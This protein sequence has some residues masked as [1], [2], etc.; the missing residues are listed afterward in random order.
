MLKPP[1][2]RTPLHTR[3][4]TFRG[5][6]REDGLWDLEGELHDSKHYDYDSS[7]GFRRAGTPVHHLSLRVTLDDSFCIHDIE[8]SMDSTPFGECKVA[9]QTMKKMIGQRM[10]PGWRQA[11]DRTIGGVHGC[12]HL[13]ELLFNMATAAFQTLPAAFGGGDP[14]TPPRHLGQ[15]TGWDFE[16]NGVKEYFPQFYG[17]GEANTQPS[18]PHNPTGKKSF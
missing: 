17:R 8:T 5:Y 7:H 4:I 3:A 15:C 18:T 13:R 9:D 12:T 14:D 16:G 10:G 2:A 1:V 6:A 11:I